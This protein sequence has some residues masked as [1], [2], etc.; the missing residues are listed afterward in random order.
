MD[1]GISLRWFLV[2]L[3][4]SHVCLITSHV[5]L[6]CRKKFFLRLDFLGANEIAH[7]LFWHLLS[8]KNFGNSP[9]LFLRFSGKHLCPVNVA[10]PTGGKA[11]RL[12][13]H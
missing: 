9:K 5:C 3:V 7:A 1:V 13:P 8:G 4:I 10:L 6:I 11:I 2:L 12:A